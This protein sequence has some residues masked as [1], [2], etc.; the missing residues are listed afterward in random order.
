MKTIFA[1]LIMCC[2]YPAFTQNL[3]FTTF[4]SGYNEPV[5]IAHCG[6]RRLF[7][8]ERAGTISICDSNGV[9]LGVPFLDI[10]SIVGSGGLEQGLLGLAFHPAYSV[11]GYFYVNYTDLSGN[12]RISRFTRNASNVN[13]ADAASEFNI[14]TVS[15]P[16]ANHNGG[17]LKFGPDGYL[18][19]ALG[20]GGVPPN[21]SN[22]AQNPMSLLGKILRIDVDAA[23]PYA[24]PPDNPY[25]GNSNYAPE[26][27]AMGVRNPWKFSFD[28]LNGD[29]WIAD[30]G[31]GIEELNYEPAGTPGRNYGWPCHE[32]MNT[33]YASG[34]FCNSLSGATL[35]IF[36]Y[37]H[38]STT[39]GACSI[40][41]GYR[42]RGARYGSLFGQ[43]I[44]ADWCSGEVWL[45]ERNNNVWNTVSQGQ[46][47]TSYVIWSFGEDVNGDLYAVMGSWWGEIQRIGVSNS[48]AP[49]AFIYGSDSVQGPANLQAG[50][51]S[52]LQYQW[53]FNGNFIP[54]AN[55]V[56]YYATQSGD[57]SV[58]VTDPSGNCSDTSMF[59][60]VEVTTDISDGG[61]D[62]NS[63]VIIFPNPAN[64]R[65]SIV[66]SGNQLY[67]YRLID[68]SGRVLVNGS[69]AGKLDIDI[70]YL[71]SGIY[72]TEIFFE[73]SCEVIRLVKH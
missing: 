25:V 50:F 30:V 47:L 16:Q 31:D 53:L 38:T 3:T 61:V 41:G 12:T 65:I 9:R 46:V 35:P 48:C 21:G 67:S 24:I 52:G 39:P 58:I 42:Y 37:N 29:I 43:Y 8:V 60:N 68:V 33:S 57:Y 26:I 18:Y 34:G 69:T 49:A 72:F 45:T 19:I 2:A 63:D 14:L 17:S 36:D 70:T 7:V 13:L 71:S 23:S 64:D 1:L 66:P 51:A 27:W 15:Q 28:R 22:N 4:S 62:A 32:G 56:N 40:I 11:N 44:F 55:S 5:A 6:D 20:D 73:G 59:V 54:G 10:T